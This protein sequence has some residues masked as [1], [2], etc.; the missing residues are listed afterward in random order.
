MDAR[1]KLSEIYR[2]QAKPDPVQAHMWISLADYANGFSG[3]LKK[4]FEYDESRVRKAQARL[5]RKMTRPEIAEAERL[6][7]RWAE[8][9]GE[10]YATRT[11]PDDAIVYLTD[12]S[13]SREIAAANG[14]LYVHFSSFDENCLP[15]IE[16]NARIDDLARRY[17]GQIVFARIAWEP[18]MEIN[19]EAGRRYGVQAL[20]TMLLFKDAREYRRWQ[21][22]ST[23]RIAEELDR[24]CAGAHNR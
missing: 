24:C 22:A 8:Q 23:D 17:A 21:G 20:P 19:R 14:Y 16:S 7:V 18:W 3:E 10:S 9:H 11:W 6:A 4:Y 13:L 12:R 15:C 5:R 2:E 1:T